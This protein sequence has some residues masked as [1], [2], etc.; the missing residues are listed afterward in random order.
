MRLKYLI[1]FI[2]AISLGVYITSC[3]SLSPAPPQNQNV[4][5]GTSDGGDSSSGPSIN[6][7]YLYG[8]LIDNYSP[9]WKV[10][11]QKDLNTYYGNVNTSD[12]KFSIKV[13][14]N[15]GYV[16]VIAF[17]DVNN[18][19]KYDVG[20]LNITGTNVNVLTND[21]SNITISIPATTSQTVTVYV[22]NNIF[23]LKVGVY[24]SDPNL[25]SIV[26][27][28]STNATDFSFNLTLT[29][30]SSSTNF[31]GIYIDLN[32]N[33]QPDVTNFGTILL[34]KEPTTE[35]GEFEYTSSTNLVIVLTPH[36]IQGNVSQPSGANFNKVIVSESYAA[37]NSPFASI[38]YYGISSISSGSYEVKFYTASNTNVISFLGVIAFN[39][40]NNDNLLLSEEAVDI[41]TYN[42]ITNDTPSTDIIN[43]DIQELSLYVSVTGQDNFNKILDIYDYFKTFIGITN[44]YTSTLNKTYY[45]DTSSTPFYGYYI[46]KDNNNNGF[47][48]IINL[49]STEDIDYYI[50][51]FGSASSSKI[52]NIIEISKLNVNIHITNATIYGFSKPKIHNNIFGAGSQVIS[53]TSTNISDYFFYISNITIIDDSGTT[54]L[55][56][57]P[58]TLSLFDD[59][60]DNNSFDPYVPEPGN[61]ATIDPSLGSTNIQM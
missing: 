50:P 43:F 13:P 7:V 8:Q 27:S 36:I 19:N 2:M 46:F 35:A 41:T 55:S 16:T 58:F 53:V 24:L 60:N 32:D 15:S 3:S 51:Y 6:Y 37:P 26:A 22:S 42:F 49:G 23:G 59:I 10:F 54:T 33:N 5:G 56:N 29:T 20:E 30:T 28:E 14:E 21:I 47:I 12:G 38:N 11:A 4:G 25:G 48:D 61:T 57:I 34:S 17:K 18:N 52:T 44:V 9:E 39:D 1:I 40:Q 31:Y 45:Y